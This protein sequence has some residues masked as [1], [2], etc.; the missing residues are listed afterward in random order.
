MK[1]MESLTVATFQRDKE[2]RMKIEK[3]MGKYENQ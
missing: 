2:Q 3:S 1:P